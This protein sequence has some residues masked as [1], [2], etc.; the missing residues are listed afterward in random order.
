MKT[1]A[2]LPFVLASA[3]PLAL[4]QDLPLRRTFD[5]PVDFGGVADTPNTLT[6]VF[7]AEL[8]GDGLVDLSVFHGD[9]T[10]G[11]V[12][13][14]GVVYGAGLNASPRTLGAAAHDVARFPGL[15]V[16]SQERW[17]TIDGDTVTISEWRDSG[18]PVLSVVSQVTGQWGD[19]AQ[20]EVSGSPL[21][22]VNHV[23]LLEE[24]QRTLHP[25]IFMDSE[26][27]PFAVETPFQTSPVQRFVLVDLDGNGA[28]DHIAAAHDDRLEIYEFDG[29]PTGDWAAG[30]TEDVVIGVSNTHRLG[31]AEMVIYISRH[32]NEANQKMWI[33]GDGFVNGP[34]T[35]PWS[36]GTATG[37][38]VDGDGYPEIFL[39]LTDLTM[40]VQLH[41]LAGYTYDMVDYDTYGGHAEGWSIP[42]LDDFDLDGPIDDL[43]DADLLVITPGEA[44]YYA[45]RLIPEELQALGVSAIDPYEGT[46]AG[47]GGGG[48]GGG[49]SAGAPDEDPP[50]PNPENGEF[51]R[52]VTV[53]APEGSSLDSDEWYLDYNRY[54]QETFDSDT[55][56]VSQHFGTTTISIDSQSGQI[57]EP[58][59]FDFVE[60]V[61]PTLGDEE[62]ENVHWIEFRL[63]HA[64][65][66]RNAPIF[67]VAISTSQE[68]Q[69]QLIVM[70]QE[71]GGDCAFTDNIKDENGV[72]LV[73]E[74]GTP[75]V[76]GPLPTGP[77]D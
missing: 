9:R 16:D 33:V 62:Y 56:L 48:Q 67:V 45:N 7:G 50:G 29:A 40:V 75:P 77:P 32:A 68:I 47:G 15:G 72:G 4:A 21:T 52:E 55:Y 49:K 23:V 12:G 53:Y 76:V 18:V 2:I 3:S 10:P 6:R 13:D 1:L 26:A 11:A 57:G 28:R 59:C 19:L 17:A 60:T 43:G 69:G 64:E 34:Y 39:G 42:V 37:R 73:P 51:V 5:L 66:G 41:G 63:R 20:I 70:C 14:I 24:N 74:S 36:V 44:F 65:T 31:E 22:F 71:D 30:H 38:D 58:I 25:L 27:A 46:A 61:N 54:H 35:L 8:T